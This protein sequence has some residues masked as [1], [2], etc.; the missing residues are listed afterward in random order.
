MF[1]AGHKSLSR[2]PF[3]LNG[4]ATDDSFMRA[5]NSFGICQIVL[6]YSVRQ[7][8]FVKDSVGVIA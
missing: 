4:V 7:F 5:I 3:L 2:C 1:R 6:G 8:F